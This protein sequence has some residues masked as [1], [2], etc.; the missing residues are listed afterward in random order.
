MAIDSITILIISL[1][2]VSTTLIAFLLYRNLK[3]SRYDKE[4]QQA[5]LD[6]I[7][8]ALEKQMY[9]IND[10][11]LQNEERWRDVNHLLYRKEQQYLDQLSD[12]S[13]IQ[14]SNFLKVNGITENDLLIDE[15]LIFVLT[16]F[17]PIMYDQFM[18]IKETCINM[19][20]NCKRG[21]EDYFGGDIF[22]KILELI[23]K[24]RLIIAN[25]NG[26]SPNVLYELGVAQALDKKVI[27]VAKEPEDLP[28]DIKSQRFLIYKDSKDLRKQLRMELDKLR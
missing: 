7:R 27:L 26:R 9:G 23:V 13:R 22:P 20:F 25:I 4:R 5:M 17:H 3:K 10:R 1:I 11:L 21:D 12:P 16:P 2:I 28:V 8:Y 6:D 15:T 14:L 19:G 24:A 18:T